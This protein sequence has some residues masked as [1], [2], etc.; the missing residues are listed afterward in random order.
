MEIQSEGGSISAK[1][2]QSCRDLILAEFFEDADV[3]ELNS[4]SYEFERI[5][6]NLERLS[7]TGR[8]DSSGFP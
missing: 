3:A 2:Q 6:R 7:V 8:A 1:P 4:R 5:V